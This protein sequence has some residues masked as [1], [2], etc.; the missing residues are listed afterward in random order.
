[1]QDGDDA[2][3]D[4]LIARWEKPLLA[5]AWRYLRHTIDAR[6]VVAETFVRLYQQRHRFRP[7]T[8]LSAWLFTAVA[9][10]CRNQH[11]W[12]IRHPTTSLDGP[13]ADGTDATPVTPM[14]HELGPGDALARKESLQALTEA[15]ERLP[16]DLKTAL[17]LHHF[18][19]LSYR[20]I[21]DMTGCQER[22]VETRLYR[23]R[24]ALRQAL[25]AHRHETAGR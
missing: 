22:G 7:E 9:N 5:F 6:D 23:A 15:M 19:Q 2:A 14:D 13:I 10:R 20:E 24:Q 18:E 8:N 12:R 11:R 16:H 4:R 1:L 3:L 25:S 21:G 17:F